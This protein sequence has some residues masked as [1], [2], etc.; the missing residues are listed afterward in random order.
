MGTVMINSYIAE[1]NHF[2]SLPRPHKSSPGGWKAIRYILGTETFEKLATMGLIANLVVYLNTRYNMDNATSAYVFNIWSGLTNFLPLAGAFVSDAFLGRFGTLLFGTTALLLGMGTMTL[3]AGI[4]MLR[5][6]SCINEES[7]CA[8]PQ[9]WQLAVLYGGLALIA[10][11]SGGVRP[12]NIAFGAD[13]FDPTTEKGRAQLESFC[14]WWY[15]LCTVA[16]MVALTG[17]VYVQTNVDWILGFAIP[18]CCLALSICSLLL[19]C[20][21]YIRMEPQ[22]SIFVD[23]AKVITAACRKSGL[24]IG[25]P[26]SKQSYYDPP[27]IGLEPQRM[28]LAH[29]NMFKFLD[30]AAIITDPGELDSLGKPKNGWRLCSLQEVEQLKRVIGVLPVW[31]TGIGCAVATTQMKSFGVLQAIQMNRS[32]GYLTHLKIPP[33]WMSLTSMIALS[34]WIYTYEQVY[35]PLMR[36]MTQNDKRLT[37][38]QRIVIGV[39]MSILCM[40]V[41]GFTEMERRDSA[42][43]RGSFES[44]IT[45]ALLLPQFV[46]SGLIEAFGAI[47]MME[48]LTAHWPNNMK[49]LGGAIFYLSFTIAGC[50]NSILIDIFLKVAWINGKLPWLGGNDLNKNRLEYFYFTV[51]ALST[52]NLIYFR[53]FACRYLEYIEPQKSFHCEANDLEEKWLQMKGTDH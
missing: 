31:L 20:H 22:G 36:K 17:V 40:L 24:I 25:Q 49:T 51:A 10:L 1:K 42:L 3:T 16:L 5:P 29:S 33:A 18:T 12:C 9:G 39:V 26:A 8:Q 52:L 32:I 4:P 7:N 23:M 2:P 43:K 41:A 13:Q 21:T 37:L 15:L 19:G 53:V 44:P 28:K 46:L 45:V 50:L 11:G 34:I 14:N 27:M 30:K 38:E 35:L 48:L 47:A 6:S